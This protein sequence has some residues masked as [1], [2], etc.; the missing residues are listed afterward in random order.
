MYLEIVKIMIGGNCFLSHTCCFESVSCFDNYFR[1]LFEFLTSYICII[2]ISTE[3]YYYYYYY[4][5]I[6][7]ILIIFI[8]LIIICLNFSRGLLLF[9]CHRLLFYFISCLLLFIVYLFELLTFVYK[10]IHYYYK[11]LPKMLP[12]I[13]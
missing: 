9:Y 4:Y 8:V 6:N 13:V 7:I 11:F 12:K 2:S 5:Y 1:Y 10:F 3:N